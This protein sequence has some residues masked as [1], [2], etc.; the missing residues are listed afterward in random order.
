MN[1]AASHSS[2]TSRAVS[3]TPTSL[4]LTPHPKVKRHDAHAELAASQSHSSQRTHVSSH[5]SQYTCQC[6]KPPPS[7]TVRFDSAHSS[8][9]LSHQ[10]ARVDGCRKSENDTSEL[11]QHTLSLT[12]LIPP[13]GSMPVMKTSRSSAFDGQEAP[14]PCQNAQH[15][16]RVPGTQRAPAR[17]EK[18]GVAHINSVSCYDAWIAQALFI[19]KTKSSSR[20]YCARK[21]TACKRLSRERRPLA[22]YLA[23]C[24]AA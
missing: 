6:V 4:R 12:E 23:T 1:V 10:K 17:H 8:C 14:I 7:R 15:V 9:Q 5:V 22:T 24:S 13:V 21:L 2:P 3:C 11:P 20:S 18:P 16:P 19:L